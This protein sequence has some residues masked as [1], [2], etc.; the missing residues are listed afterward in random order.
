MQTLVHKP[1]STMRP[2]PLALTRSET[3]GSSQVSA[4]PADHPAPGKFPDLG[5]HRA[6]KLFSATVVRMVGTLNSAAAWATR[7]RCCAGV[8]SI[9]WWRRSSATVVDHDE[10]VV[11][12][13]DQ[14]L[15]RQGAGGRNLLRR[16]RKFSMS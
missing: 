10:G 13:V 4:G 6:G 9:D 3:R 2:L 14:G 12:A 5:E 15:G 7:R 8:V 11:G 1:A 16:H